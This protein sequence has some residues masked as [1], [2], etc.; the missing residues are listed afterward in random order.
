M[1]R[2]EAESFQIAVRGPT[3]SSF[4]VSANSTSDGLSV[5]WFQV[6]LVKVDHIYSNPQ[7]GPGWWPDP[8]LPLAESTAFF[9]ANTT[10]AIWIDVRS[11]AGTRPG[12]FSVTINLTPGH[13][14]TIPVRVFD[15]QLPTT[16]RLK[17]AINLDE[18]SLNESYGL[19]TEEELH[20]KWLEYAKTLLTDYR[21]NPGT[22]YAKPGGLIPL[23]SIP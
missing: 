14:F 17:T 11:T 4:K 8:L 9:P 6:G 7:G 18:P 16:L 2:N 21:I 10:S 1:A 23:P 15:V 3:D 13:V 22:I 12:N 19:K 20:A 5:R